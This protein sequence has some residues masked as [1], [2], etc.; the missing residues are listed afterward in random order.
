MR[1]YKKPCRDDSF[2]RYL[3]DSGFDDFWETKNWRGRAVFFPI[4]LV[5]LCVSL[6]LRIIGCLDK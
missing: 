3:W 6:P 1:L 4:M 5:V 2:G